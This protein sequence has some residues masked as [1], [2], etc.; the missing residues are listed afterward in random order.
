[1]FCSYGSGYRHSN[2]NIFMI[3]LYSKPMCGACV[4][5]K[6]QLVH[7]NTPFEERSGN[8]ILEPEDEIDHE[9]FL[10]LAMSGK[11]VSPLELPQ[12]I[13]IE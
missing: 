2:F 9:M 7:D 12:E 3:Y 1:M 11:A 5:R 4:E 13:E 10:K 6:N 8:R